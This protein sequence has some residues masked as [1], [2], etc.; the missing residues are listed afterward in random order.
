MNLQKKLAYKLDNLYKRCFKLFRII[1]LAADVGLFADKLR[2]SID[3]IDFTLK[4]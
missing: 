2:F 4:K 1:D 3:E